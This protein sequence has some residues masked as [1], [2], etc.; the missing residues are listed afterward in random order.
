MKDHKAIDYLRERLDP[1]GGSER[2]AK[3][4]GVS[5]QV[6]ANWL[7][8]KRISAKHRLD[9]WELLNKHDA[10]LPLDWVRKAA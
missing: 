8:R 5:R 7:A 1:S 3:A 2:T 6:I 9:V 4:L 10:G